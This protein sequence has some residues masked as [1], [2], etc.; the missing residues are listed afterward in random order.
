VL[1][2]TENHLTVVDFEKHIKQFILDNKRLIQ[3]LKNSIY[4]ALLH[5]KTKKDG[6]DSSVEERLGEYSGK[7]SNCYIFNNFMIT[8]LSFLRSNSYRL[9]FE[10]MDDTGGF[11][12]ERYLV[13]SVLYHVKTKC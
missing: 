7:T 9:L 12:Y 8:S 3:P 2:T 5:D 11:F 6:L 10:Y 13:L 1:T 4:P